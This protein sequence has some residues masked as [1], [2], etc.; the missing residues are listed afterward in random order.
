MASRLFSSG[1]NRM[2]NGLGALRTRSNSRTIRRVQIQSLRENRSP[3][4]PQSLRTKPRNP[5]TDLNS[6]DMVQSPLHSHSILTPSVG[7]INYIMKSSFPEKRF[8]SL[9]PSPLASNSPP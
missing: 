1:V 2:R 8:P 4:S 3:Y 9:D 7:K 5:R 6:S